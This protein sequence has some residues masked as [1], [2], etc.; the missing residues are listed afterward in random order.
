MAHKVVSPKT[1]NNLSNFQNQRHI[2]NFMSHCDKSPFSKT[3]LK[4][5]GIDSQPLPIAASLILTAKLMICRETPQ[6]FPFGKKSGKVYHS[7][8]SLTE[9]LQVA[10]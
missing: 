5:L 9:Q 4:S 3:F 8:Y 10:L 1:K 2:G 7:L 6:E